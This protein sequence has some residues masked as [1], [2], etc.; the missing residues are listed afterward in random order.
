MFVPHEPMYSKIPKTKEKKK[1][2]GTSPGILTGA[3]HLVAEKT[4][5]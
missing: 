3:G 4:N 2:P 5:S 1:G